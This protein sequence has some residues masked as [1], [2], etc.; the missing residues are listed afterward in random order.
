MVF[1]GRVAD[2]DGEEETRW[3]GRKERRRDADFLF[4]VRIVISS[5]NFRRV[6]QG[7]M[8]DYK[9]SS[10]N[11]TVVADNFKLGTNGSGIVVALPN[12]V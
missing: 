1:A 3:K 8:D 6:K 5:G 2:L 10:Y 11:D 9:I 7:R 4:L 12:D